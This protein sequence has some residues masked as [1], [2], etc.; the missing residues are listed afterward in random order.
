MQNENRY[1]N[2]PVTRQPKQ[3]AQGPREEQRWSEPGPAYEHGSGHRHP[4]SRAR[5]STAQTH[6]VAQK[7]ECGRWMV[8]SD[9]HIR[10][11]HDPKAPQAERSTVNEILAGPHVGEP[12]D[13]LEGG[14]RAQ[15][16][17]RG[18]HPLG[19]RPSTR[20]AVLELQEMP[21]SADGVISTRKNRCTDAVGVARANAGQ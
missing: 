9:H 16:G 5:R 10:A 1:G 8:V 12:A 4:P 11:T 7:F 17:R 18:S 2:G 15:H 6:L 14:T 3:P 20:L 19:R 21:H 13:T